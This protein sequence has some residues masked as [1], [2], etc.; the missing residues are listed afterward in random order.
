MTEVLGHLKERI[1]AACWDYK[2]FYA[3]WD[4]EILSSWRSTGTGLLL[5][6]IMVCSFPSYITL[7]NQKT[8]LMPLADLALQLSVSSSL[9]FAEDKQA[10]SYIPGSAASPKGF[11]R[12]IA[13]SLI[14]T[15]AIHFVA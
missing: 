8:S 7:R 2:L 13:N 14:P 6:S 15:G 11:L 5:V 10:A 12:N 4:L 9:V 1:N 3:K